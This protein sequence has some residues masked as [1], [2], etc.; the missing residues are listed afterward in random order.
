MLRE[1][2]ALE[3]KEKGFGSEFGNF[4]S[5]VHNEILKGEL[6]DENLR[7]LQEGLSFVYINDLLYQLANSRDIQICKENY[8]YQHFRINLEE[9]LHGWKEKWKE[10]G[11]D[12]DISINSI[13]RI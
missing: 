11:L 8:K 9:F 5:K 2:N 10:R 4:I 3:Q 1:R 7:Q 13:K 12:V 6:E